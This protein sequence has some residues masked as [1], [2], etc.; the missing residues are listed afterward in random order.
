MTAAGARELCAGVQA[1]EIVVFDKA[2]MDFAHLADLSLREVFWVTRAKDNLQCRVVRR[3]QAGRA[4]TSCATIIVATDRPVE[5]YPVDCA[6]SP[7]WS[8]STATSGNGLPDQ[9]LTGAG[10]RRRPLRCRWQ[11]RPSSSKS[12]RPC[13]WPTSS[14]TTPTPCAGR[15]G[16]PCLPTSA[17]L[18]GLP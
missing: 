10:Q 11:S 7:P 16:R 13:N 15:S 9:Q 17:A 12:S 2:Y 3:F 8:K 5:V 6:A 1:G 14:A 4:G 18:L